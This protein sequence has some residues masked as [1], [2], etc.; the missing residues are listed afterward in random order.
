MW[1]LPLGAMWCFA[2]IFINMLIFSICADH[3]EACGARAEP[4]WAWRWGCF[5][6]FVFNFFNF[7]IFVNYKKYAKCLYISL[8]YKTLLQMH[9]ISLV[10]EESSCIKPGQGPRQT[11]LGQ[12]WP[13]PEQAKPGQ[14]IYIHPC[15][16]WP[17]LACSGLGQSWPSLV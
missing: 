2:M 13:R 15:L 7:L 5:F 4:D 9:T 14:P 6:K 3:W 8:N 1:D 10:F 12:D 16:A 11:R 17:G